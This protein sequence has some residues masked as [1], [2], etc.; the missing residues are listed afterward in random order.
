MKAQSMLIREIINSIVLLLL[1]LCAGCGGSTSGTG[2]VTVEGR[3]V[4]LNNS[5]LA[6]AQITILESGEST[7]SD[8]EGNFKIVTPFSSAIKFLVE[9]SNI[10]VQSIIENIPATAETVVV[11]ITVNREDRSASSETK[12]IRE[13]EKDD[14]A[15]DDRGDDD[16]GSDKGKGGSGQSD[17]V[18]NSNSG[19]DDNNGNQVDKDGEGKGNGSDGMSGGSS[20]NSGGDHTN[21]DTGGG[22]D[23]QGSSDDDQ[24]DDGDSDSNEGDE[25]K[26]EGKISA[27]SSSSVTVNGSTFV[28]TPQSKYQDR[29][30]KKSSLSSFA[31]GMLVSVEG[32]I[33]NGV[34]ELDK[35]EAKED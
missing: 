28:V 4:E 6:S 30:G 34:L 16:S 29:E 33:R 5:P 7:K 8:S 1:I 31:V 27:I 20:G 2:G 15:E 32:K 11:V 21:D 22:S 24:S 9:D 18:N 13:R 12:E 25:Q 17:D 10:S 19:A 14:K 35:L 3:V 23:S 26:Q